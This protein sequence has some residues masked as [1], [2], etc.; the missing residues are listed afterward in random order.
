MVGLLPGVIEFPSLPGP[1]SQPSSLLLRHSE[2][3]G[4]YHFILKWHSLV[5]A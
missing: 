3:V 2:H 5:E 1:E 4:G